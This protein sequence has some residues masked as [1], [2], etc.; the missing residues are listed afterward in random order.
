MDSRVS[1]PLRFPSDKVLWPTLALSRLPREK[2]TLPPLGKQGGWRAKD[3]TSGTPPNSRGRQLRQASREA[4]SRLENSAGREP[5]DPL[6]Q[7]LSALFYL[8]IFWVGW[9]RWR[10]V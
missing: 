1:K 9:E 10:Y 5:S 6:M 3:L 2:N 8:F 7:N 4:R